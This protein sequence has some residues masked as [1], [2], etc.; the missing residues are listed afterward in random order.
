M[1]WSAPH[2]LEV[3]VSPEH[4]LFA[5]TPLALIAVLGLVAL[6]WRLA[7]EARIVVVG[8][9]A[10]MA[11]QVYVGGS[12]ESWT[13]AGA[14]GQRRFVGTT[15]ELTVGVAAVLA[16]GAEPRW[17]RWMTTAVV[18]LAMWWNIALMV[19]FGAGWMDRQRL[20][21]Q[22]VAYNTFVAVPRALPGLAWRYL[23]DR[24][25]FY[26]SRRAGTP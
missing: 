26:Q 22:A 2:A 9:I 21:L 25:S 3:L 24:S 7:P 18:V 15:A 10:A 4:G 5:W 8:L 17:R 11:L 6:A 13:V 1:T 16:I 12:V 14:F 23:S 19:Q 20:D